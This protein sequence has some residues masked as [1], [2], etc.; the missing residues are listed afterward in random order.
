MAYAQVYFI[1]GTKN[2]NWKKNAEFAN[3]IH[4]LLEQRMPGISRGVYAKSHNGNAEYNQSLS[5][6]SILME[7]GGPYNTLEEMYRTADLL[8]E[9]IADVYR[10]A[11]KVNAT[12]SAG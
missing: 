9:L 12:A 3:R 1:V 2:P 7:I 5:P 6:N 8:A 4:K 11:E 10:Q